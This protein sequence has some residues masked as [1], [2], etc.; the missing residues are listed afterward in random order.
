MKKKQ[1]GELENYF[2]GN[3]WLS[4]DNAFCSRQLIERSLHKTSNHIGLYTTYL[5]MHSQLNCRR[6][7]DADSNKLYWRHEIKV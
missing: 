3:G 6:Q 4:I 7:E 2:T 1:K 5:T